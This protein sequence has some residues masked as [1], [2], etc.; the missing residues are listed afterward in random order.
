M[1]GNGNNMH[2]QAK[3]R[4]KDRVNKI[5][6]SLE[7]IY[8]GK[9]FPFKNIRK[10]ICNK[11]KGTGLKKN[12]VKKKCSICNGRGIQVKIIQMGPGMIQQCQ[13]TCSNC[14]GSGE[15]VNK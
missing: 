13:T 12:A 5:E 7:D 11:C 10:R 9:D 15:I 3:K 1:F 8:N 6:I 14:E 4:S 2:K